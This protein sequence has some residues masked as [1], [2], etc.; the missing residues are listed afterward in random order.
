MVGETAT[1]RTARWR[2]PSFGSS[3]SRILKA[4]D[5]EETVGGGRRT[6]TALIRVAA[7]TG[8]LRPGKKDGGMRGVSHILGTET[9]GEAGR[10]ETERLAATGSTAVTEIGVSD[11]RVPDGTSDRNDQI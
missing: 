2:R 11:S 6:E 4:R 1:G 9:I 5:R 10:V 8:G 7:V 3:S